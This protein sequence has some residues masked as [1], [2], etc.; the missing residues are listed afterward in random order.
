MKQDDDQIYMQYIEQDVL[1]LSCAIA[2]SQPFKDILDLAASIMDAP[3]IMTNSRRQVIAFSDYSLI[4]DP[5][6]SE[7][8]GFRL[9][10]INNVADSDQILC[11]K[12]PGTSG[13]IFCYCNDSQPSKKQ[14]VLLKYVA[15]LLFSA[16]NDTLDDCPRT[17]GEELLHFLLNNHAIDEA[18]ELDLNAA[19]PEHMQVVSTGCISDK[20]TLDISLSLLQALFYTDMVAAHKGRYAIAL[21]SEMTEATRLRVLNTLSEKGM[22]IGVSAPFDDIHLL[23]SH[24]SQAVTAVTETDE[25]GIN[26]LMADYTVYFPYHIFSSYSDP[27]S[28]SRYRHPVIELTERYDNEHNTLLSETLHTYILCNGNAVRTA[29]IL[30]LHKNSVLRRLDKIRSLTSYAV[31]EPRCQE[32][33]HYAY[34]IERLLRDG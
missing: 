14:R 28:F 21:I 17:K 23:R 9:F 29:E 19:L 32:S 33:L 6:W 7:S 4:A 12:A 1:T 22:R 8:I 18:D 10:A 13:Y 5:Q 16:Y 34:A 27:V 25:L 20:T 15:W 2:Q 24:A 31:T 26:S 30:H 11:E 3:L